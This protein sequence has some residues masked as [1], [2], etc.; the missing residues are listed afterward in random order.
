MKFLVD[1]IDAIRKELNI[2]KLNI[3]GHSWGAV[4]ATHY[5]SRYPDRV[6]RIIFSNPAMLSRDYDQDAAALVKQKSIAADS[7]DRARIFGSGTLD[8]KKL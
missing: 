3:L 5:A 7:I 6:K 4:L 1:D 8:N 2:D